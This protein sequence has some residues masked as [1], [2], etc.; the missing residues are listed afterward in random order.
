MNNVTITEKTICIVHYCILYCYLWNL[1]HT[2]KAIN[3]Q[4]KLINNENLMKF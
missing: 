4:D 3:R 2:R 1:K